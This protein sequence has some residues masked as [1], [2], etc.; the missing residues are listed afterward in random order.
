MHIMSRC[1]YYAGFHPLGSAPSWGL[2]PSHLKDH[3][4]TFVLSEPM[5]ERLFRVRTINF[6]LH[7]RELKVPAEYR[8][9]R[10]AWITSSVRKN[11]YD[12][13]NIWNVSRSLPDQL[14]WT[15]ADVSFRYVIQPSLAKSV[16]SAQVNITQH[17]YPFSHVYLIIYTESCQRYTSEIYWIS[18]IKF[19]S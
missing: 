11:C 19:L 9:P 2:S 15:T 17:S 12:V 4:Y 8:W 18:F 1:P 10:V 6:S 13:G 14:I 5:H 3:M 16:Q 7:H